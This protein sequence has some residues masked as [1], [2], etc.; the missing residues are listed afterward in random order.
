M[1]TMAVAPGP[2]SS[3][4]GT[5]LVAFSHLHCQDFTV[6]GSPESVAPTLE[7]LGWGLAAIMGNCTCR[8]LC[9]QST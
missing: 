3:T 8:G 2:W 9:H 4:C 1:Q 6:L 7:L 5:S